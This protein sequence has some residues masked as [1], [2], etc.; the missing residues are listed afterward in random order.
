MEKASKTMD[1]MKKADTSYEV[2]SSSPAYVM[3]VFI[4]VLQIAPRVNCVEALEL[5]DS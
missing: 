5:G 3:S 4:S 1:N 2:A